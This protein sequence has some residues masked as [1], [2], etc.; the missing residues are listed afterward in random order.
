MLLELRRLEVPPGQR[1][2][3]HQLLHQEIPQMEY[4]SYPASL[5]QWGCI[6]S[7]TDK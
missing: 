6:G 5:W 3:L 2:L 1:L 4:F 7:A